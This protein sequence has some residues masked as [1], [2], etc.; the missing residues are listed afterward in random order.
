[1]RELARFAGAVALIALAA[2]A[3]TPGAALDTL[4]LVDGLIVLLAAAVCAFCAG[5]AE[6][7]RDRSPEAVPEQL[8]L[9]PERHGVTR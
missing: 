3:T 1:M 5:V 9:S 7:R 2:L 8:E 6:V 4:R